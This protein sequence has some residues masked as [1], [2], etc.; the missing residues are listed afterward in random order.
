MW[1]QLGAWLC[2]VGVFAIASRALADET[3]L[4]GHWKFDAGQ[5]DVA[6]DRSGHELD[7]DIWDADWVRGKFGTALRFDG[8]GAFVA[9]PEI[10]N[11]DG[12]SAMTVE[13]WVYWEGTGKYPNIVTGGTWSP[14]GFMLFVNDQQ[15]SFRMGRPG[16]SASE[17]RSQWRETSA[18]LLT[19]FKSETW[20]H[21]AATFQ[22]PTIKTYVN[23]QWVGSASWDYPVGHKNDLWIGKWAGTATHQGLIDEVRIFDRALAPDEI[24][25]S[26]QQQQRGRT[27]AAEGEKPYELIPRASQLA[28]SA[29]TFENRF[30]KIVISPSGRC[31]DLL[32]KRTGKNHI[33]R[34]SPL[35]S[36][37]RGD[38]VF[39]RA[40]CS[41]HENKLVFHFAKIETTVVVEVVVK[42]EY[43]LFRVD[44][45]DAPD[46]KELTFVRFNLER[47]VHVH[48]MSG[49]AADEEFA[50]CLR[51]LNLETQVQV[52]RNPPTLT[53]TAYQE[54]GINKGE[55]ALVACPSPHMRRVLQ[56]V[57]RNE[58]LPYSALGGPFAR[59]A[60]DNRGSYVFARVSENNVE[61]WI[62]LARRAGISHIHLSGWQQ[63][64]GHYEPRK[65][66]FPHGLDGLKTVADQLHEAGLKVGI[67][68]L[69]GCIS[70]H[71]PW[72][73]P[74]PDPRLATDGAFAL[75]VDLD[76][77][78]VTVLTAEPPGTYPTVW[79]YSSRGNCV[80]IDDELL[81]YSAIS[82]ESPYGF[83]HCKRGA[84][85]T[86]V[87]PHPKGAPV[88][89]LIARYGCFIPDEHSTL[90][91]EVADAI[92]NVYNACGMDQ[93]YMDGAEAMRGWYGIA[94]MRHAIYT[95]LQRPALVEAS[96]W[97][98]HSWPFHSR[99]GAWDHPKWGL[100][101]F[102][103]DHL[104]AVEQYRRACLLE[105]QLG[106]WV[107]LGPARDWDME[108]P[109]E[110]EYLCAKALGSDVP[111]SFQNVA[112]SGRPP[113]ARQEELLTTI[114]R[115]ER[116]RLANYFD[117]TVKKRLREER[118]EFRLSQD[119][120]GVWQFVPTDYL[121][122]K[123][124]GLQ[125]GT[126]TWS[127][128]NRYDAQPVQ[129]RIQA[130]YAAHPYD[131]EQSLPLADFSDDN[132]FTRGGSAARIRYS[133][134]SV[135]EPRKEGKSSGCITATNDGDSRKGA[136]ARW[137]KTSEPVVNMTPHDAVGVWIHG[138]GQG[139][140]INLQ[141][142]NLPEYFRTL[143]DHY[144]KVDFNGWRYFEL[145]MRE[146]DAAAYHDYEWPYG[147]HC[148]LH[149]SPLVR[150][151]VSKLTMYLNDLPPHQQTTCYISPVMALRTRKVTLHHPT[152]ERGGKRLTFPVDLESGM[153]IEYASP[154]DCR[155]YDERGELLQ[156]LQP[157]GDVP[158]LQKGESEFTLAGTGTPGFRSRAEVT[159]IARGSPLKGRRP[160]D[161]ID[162]SL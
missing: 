19:T 121:A 28:A 27:P 136:W 149:R 126:N 160:A 6:V 66:L 151:V 140:L 17:T 63:S 94:R 143:D 82:N 124:T 40:S 161:E 101:R 145:F 70:T 1:K 147:A 44:S 13:A 22:R 112:V 42:P 142:T 97:D 109:D 108:M 4:L 51:T 9:M 125:D 74:V 20:Y 113:S 152:I 54:H 73:R 64:L 105:A 14:G 18:P 38:Q 134:K 154:E 88:H 23:G 25:A 46:V 123:V 99:I 133:L 144:I 48:P 98:H 89:H 155:L 150:H 72:V 65:D 37:Q 61:P 122:H 159:V 2:C 93:I 115:H 35:V 67:H 157:Q 114:G 131:D 32:D 81:Q 56:E 45:V 110:I 24:A 79:A 153:Y 162:W 91:D 49:L 34:T 60:A 78:Q 29:A 92:A 117:E 33:L 100:K 158:N 107:I 39:S 128:I 85:G 96:C 103:D 111:L 52:G 84:F 138:D 7:G 12:A 69:T 75:A 130:L 148:V 87:S 156:W 16:V 31:T 95:R 83:L 21:L 119:V 47:C 104:A 141:L 86:K 3:G 43:F 120:D 80:R 30:A 26:F 11:L 76:E 62:D 58:G 116:L 50:V 71:D 127:V 90:V 135:S 5:G 102:A 10:P 139:E 8:Q 41:L 55:A 129:L 15:C 57:V 106:W 36:L 146:R 68:T 118:E 137:S 132:E 77:K 59:D 53:A